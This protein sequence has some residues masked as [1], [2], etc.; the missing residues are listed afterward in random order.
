LL[1]SPLPLL[2]VV[3]DAAMPNLIGYKE[4]D[5]STANV[6]CFGTFADKHSGVIYNDCTGSLLF[7]SLGGCICFFIMYHYKS[8]TILAFPISGLD[9]VSIFETYK[10]H[11]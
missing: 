3:Y 6:F 7:M 2:A 1:P 10:K 5:E 11:F 9:D 4:E 8:N